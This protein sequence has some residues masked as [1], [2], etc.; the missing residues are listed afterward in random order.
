MG[1]FPLRGNFFEAIFRMT[2]WPLN[3]SALTTDA[4]ELFKVRH[5]TKKLEEHKAK[6]FH[7]FTAKLLYLAK[8][9]RP[10]I[11]I[12]VSFLTTR[13]SNTDEDDW[14]KLVRCI[15]YLN[16]THHLKLKLYADN[17]TVNKWWV[18]ASYSVH[19][20]LRS[21]TGS[22][23]TIGKGAVC[24]HSLKQK[25]NTRSSTEADLVGV[26]DIASY[27]LWTRSFLAEQ[28]YDMS[29]TIIYQDNRS[30]ILLE[31]NGT[32]IKGK[33]SKH[34]DVHYFFIKDHVDSGQMD[35]I[36][37]PAKDMMVDCFTKPLQ[38]A[39]LLRFRKLILNDPNL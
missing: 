28:G 26:D 8:R 7:R 39:D 31:T 20:D 35:I 6:L 17:C 37:C 5:E 13:V 4:V 30:A 18:D 27:V 33:R 32:F 34:I 12:S 10:D 15:H 24:S 29:G 23:M 2:R 11:A 9:T 36:W 1:P 14:N 25:L 16:C 3:K 21:H 22:V 19:P 38:G